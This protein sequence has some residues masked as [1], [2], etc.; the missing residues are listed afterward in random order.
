MEQ[1]LACYCIFIDQV[2]SVTTVKNNLRRKCLVIPQ[3]KKVRIYVI[4]SLTCDTHRDGTDLED[5]FCQCQQL[6]TVMLT[7][8][9][10]LI[11]LISHWRKRQILTTRKLQ[12]GDNVGNTLFMAMAPVTWAWISLNTS[13]QPTLSNDTDYNVAHVAWTHRYIEVGKCDR[14]AKE[15]R[16]ESSSTAS[17]VGY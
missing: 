1:I 2:L 7:I 12:D 17:Y 3:L 11:W 9:Y 8:S 10:H 6:T 4:C 16:L 15:W 14:P 13:R 5:N